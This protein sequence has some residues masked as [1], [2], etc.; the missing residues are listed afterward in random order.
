MALNLVNYRSM[1]KEAVKGFWE[2][3]VMAHQKQLDAGKI[4][5]GERSGVTAGKNMDGFLA[6]MLEIIKANGLADAEIQFSRKL[7]TL[8]GFFRPTK[9]W[10]LLVLNKGILVAAIEFKSQVGPSFSNNFNNRAEESI[11]TAH[12]FWTAYRNGAFGN[13][14]PKPFLG[15]FM[16]LEDAP[17]SRSP[18]KDISPHFALLP[19]FMTASY[20]ERYNILCRKLVQ[21]QLYTAA[22][23]ILS[24]RSASNRGEYSELAEL[25]GLKSFITILAGQV[26]SEAARVSN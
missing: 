24:H 7:L 12:D 13:D 3:R 21:E 25:T 11:G 26:A 4:D 20:A 14:S 19:E 10:D 16:L 1:A 6:M 9:Q 8:P 17:G 5:Q 15:W 23:V 18:V 22:A 2:N